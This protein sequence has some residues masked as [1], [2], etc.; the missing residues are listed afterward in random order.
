MTPKDWADAAKVARQRGPAVSYR[1][2]KSSSW[3]SKTLVAVLF[4]TLAIATVLLLTTRA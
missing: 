2:G 3:L 4:L 1:D